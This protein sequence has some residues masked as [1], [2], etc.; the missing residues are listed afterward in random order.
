MAK[1]YHGSG[2]LFDRFDLSHALEGDGKVKFGYGVYLTSRFSSAAH[3]SGSNK[4]WQDHYVYTVDVPEV[5][6]EN[7]IHFQRQINNQI[8]EKVSALL[9]LTIPESKTSN[10]K[11][12]RK[13]IAATLLKR[14]QTEAKNAGKPEPLKIEGEKA[15]SALLLSAGIEYIEWPYNWKN[16]NDGTN[17]AVLDDSKINI[18]RIDSV[19]L[20]DKTKLIE[21]SEKQIR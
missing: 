4:N 14:M 12:F 13:F 2:I 6:E 3:Y 21:G 16:P 10:G 8:V 1:F 7:A 18:I 20:D 11:D 15:A 17:I 5:T 19:Q 9:G